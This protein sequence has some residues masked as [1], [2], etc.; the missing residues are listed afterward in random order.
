MFQAHSPRQPAESQPS[1]DERT[2]VS[3]LVLNP[4]SGSVSPCH[5]R[6]QEPSLREVVISQKIPL[7]VDSSHLIA[8]ADLFEIIWNLL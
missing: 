1:Q 7:S 8:L 5:A 2:Q 6:S 4:E 3:Q